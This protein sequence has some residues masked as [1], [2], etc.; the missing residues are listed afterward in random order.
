M[1]ALYHHL[2]HEAGHFTRLTIIGGVVV[3][4]C[5]VVGTLEQTVEIIGI[6]GY[7]VVDG[8][9]AIGLADAVWDERGIAD[10]LGEVA[11][12]A[13]EQ[14]YM[15]EVDVACLKDAHDLDAF[16]G[17]TV[18][19]YARSRYDLCDQS[20]QGEGIDIERTAIDKIAETVQ[21][22]VHTEQTLMGN[23]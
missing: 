16:N 9:E 15:V 2:Q 18:K 6:D 12:I 14:Q 5:D 20:L 22:G 1:V 23:G 4:Q 13:G 7:L 19:G 11:L 3:D 8:C 17:F 21:Q 10:A